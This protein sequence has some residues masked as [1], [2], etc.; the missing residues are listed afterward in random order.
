MKSG[1]PDR[2]KYAARSI[3]ELFGIHSKQRIR[4]TGS[5]KTNK[6]GDSRA[7]RTPR[8]ILYGDTMKPGDREFEYD[9]SFFWLMDTPEEMPHRMPKAL[10]KSIMSKVHSLAN[11]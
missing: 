10:D 3:A 4:D 2:K 11:S 6:S 7:S 5:F 8:R 9:D 1:Y